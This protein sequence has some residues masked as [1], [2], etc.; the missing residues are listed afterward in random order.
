MK[1]FNVGNGIILGLF[2]T[3]S[4]CLL[5]PQTVFTQ[6]EKLGAVA[7][8][9]V[10]GW[11]KTAKENIV[12]FSEIDTAAGKFCTITL[13][14]ATPGTGK[15]ESDFAREWNNLVVKPFGGG[16]SP[17]TETE[18]IGDWT[19]I[20]GGA[21]VDFSGTPA[22][23]FLTVLSREGSTV[24]ILG[25]FNDESYLTKLVAF[26]SSIEIDKPAVQIPAPREAPLPPAASGAATTMNAG[27]LVREFEVNEIRA[28]QT[29]IGKVVRI[30]GTINSILV[31]KDG[32]IAITFKST[33]GAYGNARCYFNPSQSS[34]VAAL[35]AHTEATVQGTVRGWEGG[36]SGA[37]VFV[38]L[39]DCIVP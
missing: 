12:T 1:L 7:Y 4:F 21:A 13:Y 32:K 8:S 16:A 37:K 9:P 29:Y 28:G 35:S 5:A 14:G 20:G 30:Y 27:S 17:K 3:L 33:L 26:N 39:D 15:A 2:V 23:A 34:R 36:Y 6:T 24:S 25:V 31:G 22:I 10:K 18:I 11:K 38:F 19:A